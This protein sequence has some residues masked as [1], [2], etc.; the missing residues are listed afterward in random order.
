MIEYKYAYAE[1][2]V[3]RERENGYKKICTVHGVR[4]TAAGDKKNLVLQKKIIPRI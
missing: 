2:Y 1:R 4:R 3:Y